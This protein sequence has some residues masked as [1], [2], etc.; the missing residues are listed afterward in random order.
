MMSALQSLRAL[1]LGLILVAALFAPL[2]AAAQVHADDLAIDKQCGPATVLPNGDYSADCVLSLQVGAWTGAELGDLSFAI[3]DVPS[4]A[5]GI[6]QAGWI[7]NATGC[8]LASDGQ[9]WSCNV[10]LVLWQGSNA[11]AATLPISTLSLIVPAGTQGPV[12]NCARLRMLVGM[13]VYPQ[14]TEAP[15][16]PLID[17]ACVSIEL[18]KDQTPDIPT[19]AQCM[20]F[21]PEVTCDP[22]TGLPL[23][24]LTNAYSSL[25]ASGSVHL[26]SLTPGV[27]VAPGSG[28]M[29][30][31]LTGANPGDTVHLFSEAVAP[32]AGSAP[33]LDLCCMGDIAVTIPEGLLCTPETVLEVEKICTP[34]EY[35]SGATV[36]CEI[37]VTYSGPPPTAADPL[38][39]TDAVSAGAWSVVAY[40]GSSDN[41]A[42]DPTPH[43]GPGSW[44]CAITDAD[45]PGA[46]WSAFTSILVVQMSTEAAFENCAEATAGGIEDQA[47]WSN[48]PPDITIAKTGPAEC[49]GEG[50]CDYQVTL[51][52]GPGGYYGPVL[53]SDAPPA[54]FDITAIAPPIAGCTTPADPLACVVGVGLA[55]GAT[56][57][58][59]ITIARDGTLDGLLSGENCAA[60]HGL[61]AGPAP[62]AD[63]LAALLD[64]PPLA[65]DCVPVVSHDDECPEGQQMVDGQCVEAET[66]AYTLA[67]TCEHIIGAIDGM[68]C[69]ITLTTNGVPFSGVITVTDVLNPPSIATLWAPVGICTNSTYSCDFTAAELAGLTPPDTVQITVIVPLGGKPGDFQNCAEGSDS[70]EQGAE[71]CW[72]P[73]G[74]TE[75]PAYTVEKT[76]EAGDAA[77]ACTIIV[78]TNGVDFDGILTISDE[79]NLAADPNATM[80]S[81][82]GICDNATMSCSFTAADF[83]GMTPANTIE[84]SVALPN[85]T[86]TE[87]FMQCAEGANDEMGPARDCWLNGEF[88]HPRD[89]P[90]PNA[91]CSS[92]YLFVIDSSGSIGSNVGD[93]SLAVRNMAGILNGM[94]SQAGMIQFNSSASVTQPMG[95]TVLNGMANNFGI[96]FTP[97]GSTNWEA[98]LN[99]AAAQATPTTTILFITDGRPTAYLDTAGNPVVLPDGPATWLTA[100]NEA[101]PAVNTLYGMGVPI[102]GIGIAGPG[103]GGFVSTYLDALLGTQTAGSTFGSL[104]GDLTALANR[105]CAGLHVTKLINGNA[106]AQVNFAGVTGNTYP[107]TITL[108]AFNSGST[109]LTNV[110][111][112][113][114]LPANLTNPGSVL[115]A[116]APVTFTGQNVSWTVPLI[117][118]GTTV[119]VTY[120]VDLLRPAPEVTSCS[121]QANYAQVMSLTGDV[122]STAG[123]MDPASGPAVEPDESRARYCAYD[124]TSVPTPCTEQWLEVLKTADDESCFTGQDCSFTVTLRPRSCQPTGFSGPVLF[125][126]VVNQAGTSVPLQ[127]TSVTNNYGTPICSFPADWSGASVPSGCTTNVTIPQG[128]AVTFHVTTT[129]PAPG[130]YTNCFL[131][132]D[133]NL[134]T[135]AAGAMASVNPPTS[136]NLQQPRGNCVN[137][138]VAAPAGITPENPGD[139]RSTPAPVLTITKEPVGPCRTS[140]RARQHE[141]DFRLTVS[142]SGDAP[143]AGP[144]V[145]SD[146]V[147]GI[148]PSGGRMEAVAGWN[149][150]FRGASASCVNGS[151]MLEPGQSIA[152]TLTLT[153]PGSPRAVSFAQC[154]AIGIGPGDDERTMLG[155]RV[156]Q[157]FGID[158]GPVDG[159]PGRQTRAGMRQLYE[160][161]GL[162]ANET[163]TPALLGVLGLGEA[164]APA[165][166]TVDLPAIRQIPTPTGPV[167][168]GTGSPTATPDTPPAG[169]RCD[170]QTT[171]RVGDQCECRARTMVRRSPTACGC[172]DGTQ[173]LGALGCV[174]LQLPGILPRRNGP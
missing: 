150:A 163:V 81:T 106:F 174:G 12:Q 143:F 80:Y 129:A 9:S 52:A 46:D 162:P 91:S 14:G 168:G 32:G 133:R 1:W 119:S 87:G 70:F 55:A 90:P 33:G 29:S 120:T 142:N 83:Q 171:V 146:Q 123:N 121:W 152:L 77:I 6:A 164:G 165:C 68:E 151:V 111:I 147:T 43:A 31:I 57:G 160:R 99:L 67:K 97:S 86:L 161:L 82:Q 109:D 170:P 130:N 155:Q 8:A 141:C 44:S 128:G 101:I 148:T 116:G 154:A 75:I 15:P 92:D 72:T 47:C 122:P 26:S 93:V 135:T 153:L 88:D 115:P 157:L 76:C 37:A 23:V 5:G 95:P 22:A 124:H 58:Y 137:F 100:T 2:P 104:D 10:P 134:P 138:S 159:I 126:D 16:L 144:V 149:C 156:M 45:A 98:A 62:A 132:E 7:S 158:G 173:M 27:T 61:P 50:P 65:E 63:Q 20:I 18:P 25:F 105:L 42:C 145:L 53:L 3:E 103:E 49:E 13:P 94:G 59:T 74:E 48:I 117:A 172:P 107:L 96:L 140:Q 85:T 71:A 60:L 30:V 56:Q 28:P 36:D 118:A 11:S 38:T 24:T 113:D 169:P 125:G 19:G 89:P 166:V 4:D 69:T 40:M 131:A 17:E 35:P 21:T 167:G 34:G 66:P 136:P 84:I 41:W 114:L 139:V 51:T 108:S 73:E 102:I 127:V 78:T 54:G 110:V 39:I 64:T 79:Y 112:E